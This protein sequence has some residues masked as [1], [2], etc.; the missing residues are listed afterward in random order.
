MQPRV[1]LRP[2]DV[3]IALILVTAAAFAA[4][5]S[6]AAAGVHDVVYRCGDNLCRID[7]NGQNRV[8]LTTDGA[9]DPNHYSNPSMS[10][11]GARLA[12]LHQGKVYVAGANAADRREID[13]GHFHAFATLRPDGGKVAVIRRTYGLD[14][15]EIRY[16]LY[17]AN[18]DGSGLEHANTDAFTAGF[19]GDRVLSNEDRN[20]RSAL[21]VFTTGSDV[22][23][24]RIVAED[25][26]AD[27]WDPQVAP[28][29]RWM[30][31]TAFVSAA[32]QRVALWDLATGT[33]SRWLTN[34]PQ[35]SGGSWSAD[36]SMIAFERS[37]SVYV[38]PASGG[39]GTERVLVEGRE[40]TFGST[41]P[42]AT[43]G[44][45]NSGDA[46]AV[47]TT[48]PAIKLR[49]PRGQRLRGAIRRGLRVTVT[50]SESGRLSLSATVNGKTARK[51]RLLPR[52]SK[53]RSVEVGRA[54]A[55]SNAGKRIVTIKLTRKAKK[56]LRHQAKVKITVKATARDAAGN[57]GRASRVI[58]LKR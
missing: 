35:D 34:G 58:L 54:S 1:R 26:N 7:T 49:V 24:E 14:P 43:G 41:R 15:G 8:Q 18:P 32:D 27:L 55:S 57:I 3:V 17:V 37:G 36:G 2:P 21:C 33:F 10:R 38:M 4:N 46:Q 40:P 12:F 51:V 13:P 47:D 39:P 31:V 25:A 52:R 20:G 16:Y 6:I 45:G 30:T 29:L 5:A 48:A 50:S 44:D 19:L 42:D 53:R 22:R 9:P 28:D 56:A 11:D 23:C